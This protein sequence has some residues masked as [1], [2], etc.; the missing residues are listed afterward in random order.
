MNRT[1]G[2]LS[3]S[4]YK[5]T[6]M[7]KNTRLSSFGKWVSPINFKKVFEQVE[8]LKQDYY[9]KK[10]TTEAYIKLFLF[11]QLHKTESL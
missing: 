3:K 5:G 11:A 10:L 9:T 1:G 2:F 6:D 8:N 4:N 7:D